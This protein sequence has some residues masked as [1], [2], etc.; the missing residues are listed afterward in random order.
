MIEV[1]TNC[2]VSSCPFCKHVILKHGLKNS[3]SR[4]DLTC[5]SCHRFNKPD[6][7]LTSVARYVLRTTSYVITTGFVMIMSH[8]LDPKDLRIKHKLCLCVWASQAHWVQ[9]RLFVHPLCTEA[10]S[11][12]DSKVVV[13]STGCTP[14]GF[15]P[16][17]KPLLENCLTVYCSVHFIV[18]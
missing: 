1:H 15:Y 2:I 9:V 10:S 4:A 6:H 18:S 16:V 12:M 7:F 3:R 17:L 8:D 11:N 14:H 13:L 5:R